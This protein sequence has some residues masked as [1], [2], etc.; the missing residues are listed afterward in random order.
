MSMQTEA[1][2]IPAYTPVVTGSVKQYVYKRKGCLVDRQIRLLAEAPRNEAW[3]CRVE[4]LAAAL[5]LLPD[6]VT[7]F[8]T[9]TDTLEQ[10]EEEVPGVHANAR[11]ALAKK[12][13]AL[14]DRVSRDSLPPLE[15]PQKEEQWCTPAYCARAAEICGARIAWCKDAM[16]FEPEFLTLSERLRSLVPDTGAFELAPVVLRSAMIDQE[17]FTTARTV[18]TAP[19]Y[20]WLPQVALLEMKFHRL[21]PEERQQLCSVPM[22]EKLIGAFKTCMALEDRMAQDPVFGKK[23]FK[24]KKRCRKRNIPFLSSSIYKQ[25]KQPQVADMLK[26]PDL[27]QCTV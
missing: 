16:A 25:C 24:E 20:D 26:N 18:L 2:G 5:V 23:V 21:S 22:L 1:A 4:R 6:S 19:V 12:A 14:S 13:A 9:R 27:R 8:C 7:R 15:L 10:L 17:V 11:E 3:A